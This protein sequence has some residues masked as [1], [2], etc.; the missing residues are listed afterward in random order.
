MLNEK[1]RPHDRMRS[2]LARI[3][4]HTATPPGRLPG[5]VLR[6]CRLAGLKARRQELTGPGR[7][8]I[9]RQASGSRHFRLNTP[10]ATPAIPSASEYR[11]ADALLPDLKSSLSTIEQ[12]RDEFKA[13]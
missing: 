10:C 11:P 7:M 4:A 13:V 6:N 5:G 1:P 12:L 9:A 8:A 3:L 2:D